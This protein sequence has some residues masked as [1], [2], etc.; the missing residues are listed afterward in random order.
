MPNH[1]TNLITFGAD[2]DSLAAF[3]RMLHDMREEDQPLGSFDFN[4]LIPMPESLNIEAGSR[5]DAG[6]KLFRAFV[7]ESADIAKAA[8]FVSDEEGEK[9]AA[10]HLAKWDARKNQDPEIWALG[11]TAFQNIQKYG[12]PTWYEWS[13]QNWGTKW[14]SYQSRPLRD[15][16]DTMEFLTAWSA[17]PDLMKKLSAK[18]PEQT[19][20]YRWAD[21][22]VGYNVGELVLKGG[23]IIESSIPEPG[24]REAYEM[25]SEIMGI[26]LADCGLYLNQDK[27]NY[28]YRKEPPAE[29]RP[30]P[31]KAVKSKKK[32][33]RSHE[34]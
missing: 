15:G 25:A 20:T 5:T 31:A 7:K 6:L 19:I 8:L 26:D 30:Q 27:T 33:A 22:D 32:G 10:A 11:E 24:S 2:S 17:I 13:N 16:D 23:D 34:R 18:Y 29:T 9:M 28:E 4:K 12:C 3:Q 1:I 21:E 14:N